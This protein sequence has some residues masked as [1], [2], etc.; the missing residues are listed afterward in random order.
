MSERSPTLSIGIDLG[1]TN[2]KA[3]VLQGDDVIHRQKTATVR[4]RADDTI[5]ALAAVA[6]ELTG[7]FPDPG[8]TVGVT[9][10]GHCDGDGNA[11]VIP[12]LP[13]D[14]PGVAVRTPIEAACG[15]P[16]VLINDARAFGLAEATIGAGRG[17]A[18]MVGVVLGT[19]IG[20]VVVI[21]G[22]LH[23][24]AAGQAG[25]IGHQVLVADGPACGCG[26]HGCLESLARADVIAAAAGVAGMQDVVTAAANRDPVAL[27]ALADAG[28]WIGHGLANVVTVLQPDMVVVGGGLSQAGQDLMGPL[29]ERL[30]ALTPLVPAGSYRVELAALGPWAGAVGAA[31]AGRAAG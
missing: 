6:A 10:P 21:G 28:R 24:G 16:V 2:T 15:R 18:T 23:P 26:N 30:L 17:S 5:A 4:G 19:G 11:L 29:R 20:G 9:V 13:G 25:E 7:R 1:G 14:W 27:Q 22:R 31:V 12:N 8:A 3:V